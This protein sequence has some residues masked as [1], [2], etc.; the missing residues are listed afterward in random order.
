MTDAEFIRAVQRL[1]DRTSHWTPARWAQ[2]GRADVVHGLVQRLA[3]AG[4]EAEGRPSRPVPR[5]ASDL[6]LTDQLRVVAADLLAAGA[7]APALSAATEAV[8]ATTRELA[9]P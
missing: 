1:L 6:A 3:D 2:R 8:R 5:L 9:S 4:E 7:K